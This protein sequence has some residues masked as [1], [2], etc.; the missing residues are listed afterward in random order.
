MVIDGGVISAPGRPC[1]GRFG[2]ARGEVFACMAETMLLTLSD[3]CR[4]ASLGADLQPNLLHFLREAAETH[5]FRVAQLKSFGQPIATSPPAT[6]VIDLEEI[7][8]AN[9]SL[10]FG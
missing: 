8:S 10:V 3:R 4:D 2:L 7:G 5:G 1:L 9:T 6:Q